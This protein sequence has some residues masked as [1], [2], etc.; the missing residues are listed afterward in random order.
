M[1]S[2]EGPYDHTDDCRSSSSL[3]MC[4][5][6]VAWALVVC[7]DMGLMRNAFFHVFSVSKYHYGIMWCF[8]TGYFHVPHLTLLK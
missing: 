2:F 6:V 3:T 7:I 1:F 8:C 4:V 5:N